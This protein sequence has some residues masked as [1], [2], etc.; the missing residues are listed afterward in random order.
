MCDILRVC[1]GQLPRKWFVVGLIGDT[2]YVECA[3]WAAGEC[4][5]IHPLAL[6]SGARGK[7]GQ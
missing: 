7:S 5:S 1:A 2:E 6:A 4:V 3:E